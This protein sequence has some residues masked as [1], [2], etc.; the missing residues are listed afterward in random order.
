MVSLNVIKPNL[1]GVLEYI[2]KNNGNNSWPGNGYT[3]DIE[4]DMLQTKKKNNCVSI[5]FNAIQ[6]EQKYVSLDNIAA[7]HR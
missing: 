2:E 3:E 7:L 6:K 1:G 5:D 4:W